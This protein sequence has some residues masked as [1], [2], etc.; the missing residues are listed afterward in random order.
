MYWP[1]PNTTTWPLT[2]KVTLMK[3]K[4]GVAHTTHMA[5][6]PECQSDFDHGLHDMLQGSQS[7]PG[8]LCTLM[9]PADHQAGRYTLVHMFS[10]QAH[11]A[12][13]RAS[14]TGQAWHTQCQ[15]WATPAGP[16]YSTT[17]AQGLFNA[18]ALVPPARGRFK[19]RFTL[20]TWLGIFPTV[21][22]YLWL[23]SPALVRLPFLAQIAVLTALIVVTM[24]YGVMPQ[25]MRHLG[26]WVNKT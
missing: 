10:S 11:L 4:Q 18:H 6:R 15:T 21:S 24:S 1:I 12:N 14:T 26:G 16:T 22:A 23:V 2:K 17:R 5:I 13:W 20:V 25:L 9:L 19:L 8:H 3:L 7:C